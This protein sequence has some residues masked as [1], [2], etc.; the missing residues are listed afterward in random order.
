MPLSL[1]FSVYAGR[2]FSGISLLVIKAEFHTL[3]V[4]KNSGSLVGNHHQKSQSRIFPKRKYCYV[5]GGSWKK[6]STG[7]W[8]HSVIRLLLTYI[9]F[10]FRNW[11][12]KLEGKAEKVLKTVILVQDF[13]YNLIVCIFIKK[14][15]GFNKIS[16]FKKLTNFYVFSVIMFRAWFL[17]HKTNRQE[18]PLIEK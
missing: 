6:C 4:Q 18:Q 9:P 11:P 10:N 17:T 16:G 12:K 2:F 5:V 7:N 15:F 14:C 13:P 3:I 1:C 8:C